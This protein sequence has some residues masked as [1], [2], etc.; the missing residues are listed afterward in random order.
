MKAD[1]QTTQTVDCEHGFHAALVPAPPVESDSSV[2]I[3]YV[4]PLCGAIEYTQSWGKEAWQ[5]E[6]AKRGTPHQA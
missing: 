4:C 6:L 1:K 3:D 2:E 5:K